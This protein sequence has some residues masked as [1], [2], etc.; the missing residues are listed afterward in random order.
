MIHDSLCPC[1]PC[2]KP[3]SLDI[4]SDSS[5]WACSDCQGM[6]NCQCEL[7]SKVRADERLRESARRM[8]KFGYWH[9]YRP[10]LP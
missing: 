9:D 3:H 4:F 6:M 7:I 8:E 10:D 2:G 1:K 5:P